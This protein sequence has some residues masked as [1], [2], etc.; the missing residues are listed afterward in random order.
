M[1]LVEHSVTHKSKS[2]PGGVNTHFSPQKMF[3]WKSL[4]NLKHFP[5]LE[6][7]FV[8][9]GS[10]RKW[11]WK[12]V[13]NVILAEISVTH[14]PKSVSGG[15]QFSFFAPKKFFLKSSKNLEHFL[16]LYRLHTTSTSEGNDV[17]NLCSFCAKATQFWHETDNNFKE[18][19]HNFDKSSGFWA[20]KQ[21]IFNQFVLPKFWSLEVDKGIQNDPNGMKNPKLLSKRTRNKDIHL[22]K[23]KTFKKGISIRL[24]TCQS[25]GDSL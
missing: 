19:L 8:T 20:K 14:K 9:C 2:V 23:K 18:S 11:L 15:C 12:I 25:Y 17:Q 1:I 16:Y 22:S 5:Y 21:L 4:K 10:I 3:F 7:L 24:L 13:W 6:Y